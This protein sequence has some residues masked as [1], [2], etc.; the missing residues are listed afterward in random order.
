[1]LPSLPDSPA[2]F[3]IVGMIARFGGIALVPQV[4]TLEVVLNW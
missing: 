1:L 4:M 2:S 3:V